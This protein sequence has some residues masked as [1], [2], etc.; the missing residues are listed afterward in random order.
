MKDKKR[1]AKVGHHRGNPRLWF[2]GKWLAA[3]G[4]TPG[5]AFDCR[6]REGKIVLVAGQGS[7]TISQKKGRPV[8]DICNPIVT[9]FLGDCARVNVVVGDGLLTITPAKE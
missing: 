4:F 5:D 1:T 8:L 7:R 6:G 2:E 3:A 9:E